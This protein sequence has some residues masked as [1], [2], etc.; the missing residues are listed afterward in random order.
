M[1][2]R[3]R[4]LLEKRKKREARTQRA[5]TRARSAETAA[6]V[7]LFGDHA[8]ERRPAVSLTRSYEPPIG[9]AFLA[10]RALRIVYRATQGKQFES[11]EALQEI[12]ANAV[13][14]QIEALD[15]ADESIEPRER[16]Q[17]LAFRAMECGLREEARDWSRLALALDADCADA[18]SVL[19]L[20]EPNR[21]ATRIVLLESALEAGARAL[22]GEPFFAEHR[23]HF[24]G[25]V[26]T[27]P[28]MRTRQALADL[29][30]A[31][32]RNEE[33]ILHYSAM[34][35]LNPVDDQCARF[36]LL[37]PYLELERLEP[38]RVLLDSPSVEPL[39]IASFARALERW[40]AR[41]RAGAARAVREGERRNWYARDALLGRGE[42][43]DSNA[44]WSTGSEEEAASVASMIGR[45]WR[46]HS[47]A[48]RWLKAGALASTSRERALAM[49][50]YAGKVA[51]LL[52]LG[53]AEFGDL[54]IDYSEQ[55][56]FTEADVPELTRMVQDEALQESD[57]DR[58][59]WACVHAWRALGQLRAV[60]ALDVLA[61]IV[62]ERFEDDYVLQDLPQVFATIGLAAAG[63]V[64]ELFSDPTVDIFVRS[65]LAT[66]MTD[67]A[68]IDE[69]LRIDW[70]RQLREILQSFEDNDADL[71]ACAIRELLGAPHDRSDVELARQAFEAE[72]VDLELCDELDVLLE[73]REGI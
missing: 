71:N 69:S 66:V 40:I 60:E 64:R 45:A 54:W 47:D 3:A 11:A 19:A 15:V 6:D 13:G 14:S 36:T 10:E 7:D 30:L 21:N 18:L 58:A 26:I 67:F 38:L 28:Y 53:E 24:W 29:L 16:A 31:D 20:V 12:A 51:A 2:R 48:L 33:A 17:E 70:A 9:T 61:R 32:H 1:D 22:G 42:N 55:F 62:R 37:G 41:D 8:H 43:F 25:M 50:S 73:Q 52:T 27:R 65:S 72:A 23:G 49:R 46:G 34:L 68:R 5:R 44:G 35:D 59:A 39:A 56:A 57:D 63:A 4:K